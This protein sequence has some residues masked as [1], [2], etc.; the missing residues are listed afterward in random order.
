VK[1]Y[2]DIAGDGGSDVLG[3]VAARQRA[4]LDALAGVR[5]ILAVGSGKGGVGKSTVTLALAR[6]FRRR[7]LRIAILDA[8]LNGPSQA[9]MAGLEGAPLIPVGLPVET[10]GTRR[11]DAPVDRV[12]AG[13]GT[14]RL[15]LPRRPDGIGVVSLGS[16]LAA[17]RPLAFDTVSR[18]EQQTWRATRELALLLQLLSSVRWG[19][20]DL[21]LVDLPPG[22]ER[23]VQYAE[24]LAPLSR[25]GP[26]D[27]AEEAGDAGELRAPLSRGGS[28]GKAEEA[29]DAGELR[30][31]LSRGGPADGAAE[32]AA[33]AAERLAFVMVTVPSDVSRGVVARALA[34][35]AET[36][37]ALLGYVE[38][39]AGYLCR[40]CGEV[41][42]LFPQPT[43][44]LDAPCLGR[45]PFDPA[46]AEL[47]DR[48]WPEGSA[49]EE[50][51]EAF[52]Q[53]EELAAEIQDRLKRPSSASAGAGGGPNRESL[54]EEAV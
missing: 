19:E 3:Q 4:V 16:L 43:V 51:S 31:P 39:M 24:L 32:G 49:V 1:T 20:L 11:L 13:A 35:L 52:R 8:D 28:A 46:L 33:A 17:G 41:R 9:R 21:L 25:G 53:I 10:L 15:A 7:G 30:A 54:E 44:A 5:R 14:A 18:G 47:C 38:N 23:T 22:A 12:L 34:A 36:P 40:D 50:D 42:P 48:G 2:H 26:A 29:G 45:I 6:A 37:A 27:A